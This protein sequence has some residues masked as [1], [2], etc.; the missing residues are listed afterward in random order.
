MNNLWTQKEIELLKEHYPTK[1]A[2]WIQEN[3]LPNR[4][5]FAIR[6]KAN[7]LNIKAK[8]NDGRFKKG[9]RSYYNKDN[10]PPKHVMRAAWEGMRNKP[11]KPYPREHYIKSSGVWVME[12]E[13]GRRI[14][15]ARYLYQKHHNV[16]L[17]K[18]EIVIFKDQN[19]NNFD[20]DNLTIIKRQD[21]MYY[22]AVQLADFDLRMSNV[23]IGR[24]KRQIKNK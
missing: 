19:P 14:T 23:L 12:L 10:K 8:T 3:K 11:K 21:A 18:D 5:V 7:L 16:T 4:G 1:S 9:Q 22:S 24:I 13:D 17:S 20:I 15:K 6:K 2:A